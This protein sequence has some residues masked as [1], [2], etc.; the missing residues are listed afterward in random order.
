MKYNP[1]I[2]ETLAR[3]EKLMY[4]NPNQ[5]VETAQGILE[6][7]YE[8]QVA[9]ADLAGLKHTTLQ[10]PAG[11]SGEFCGLALIKAYHIFVAE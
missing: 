10:T 11:A 4:M 3:S 9:L 2:N 5:P 6:I 8:L 7:M 1:K